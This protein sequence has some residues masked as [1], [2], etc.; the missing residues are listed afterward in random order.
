MI[1]IITIHDKIKL[2][3]IIII[4]YNQKYYKMKMNVK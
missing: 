3:R 2:K 1:K 4:E